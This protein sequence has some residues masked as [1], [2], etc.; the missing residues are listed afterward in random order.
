MAAVRD[1]YDFID[2]IIPFGTQESWDNSGF[3][4]GD[5]NMQVHK[6]ITALDITNR[7]IDEAASENAEL[8]ISHHPVIFT[9]LKAV[10]SG[11]PVGR[12]I[13]G[14][15]SAICTH[16]PFDMSPLGMNKG[17]YELL[18]SPLGLSEGSLPLEETGEGLSVGRIYELSAPLS[19]EETAKRAKN[20]LGCSA[21][22]FSDGGREIR[23]IAVS[24]GSGGSFVRL[25]QKKGADALISG[26]FKHDAFIDSANDGFTIID[27]G[28]FH[29]ERIFCGIMK[30]LLSKEFP[31]ITVTEAKSCTDPAGYIL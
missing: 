20:A 16:T 5:P 6:I 31:H 30:E 24:S 11:S 19:P 10:M 29:T 25:A 21:V 18:S 15:I 2:R 28:H 23:K 14:N 17:L 27:C 4:V 7:V 13:S 8:I 9:P 26:D 1:I 12:M 22:R 3:L